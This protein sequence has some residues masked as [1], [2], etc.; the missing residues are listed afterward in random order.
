MSGTSRISTRVSIRLPNEVVRTLERRIDGRRS[1]W[2]TIGEYLK[3]RIIY[4]TMREHKRREVV[5]GE[6]N[7]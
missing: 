3:E 5:D 7:D 6:G 4:D 2:S 1:R